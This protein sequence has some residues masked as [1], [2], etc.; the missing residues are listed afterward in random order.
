[1]AKNKRRKRFGLAHLIIGFLL[2]YVTLTYWNQQK[3][4]AD[5]EANKQEK[6]SKVMDL[7]DEIDELEKEIEISDSLKFI[8][9]VA[10]DDLGMVK[11]REIIYIDTNKKKRNFFTIKKKDK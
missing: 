2:I 6:S 11:P 9:K 7:M 3:L 8:E 10:R 4:M 5:L 1:M